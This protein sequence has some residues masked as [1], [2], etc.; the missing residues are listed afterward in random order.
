MSS[1]EQTDTSKTLWRPWYRMIQWSAS[2]VLL[3]LLLAGFVLGRFQPPMGQLAFCAFGVL[4]GAAFA[5]MAHPLD[6]RL[7]RLGWVALG[8]VAA[9]Q[10]FF[11][12]L[13]WS[14][15]WRVQPSVLGWRLWW[16]TVVT[17]VGLGWLQVLWR[18]GARWEW[19]SG[20]TTLGFTA[21][22]GALL[23][24][25][26]FRANPSS[27]LPAWW[28][29]A[30]GV[31]ALGA[32]GGSLVIIGRW[33]KKR[34]KNV[35]PLPPWMRPAL[36]TGGILALSMGSFYIGRVT[37]PPPSPFDIMPSALA[38]MAPEQLDQQI[39]EDHRILRSLAKGMDGLR[40]KSDELHDNIARD[41]K[42]EGRTMYTP[43]ENLKIR[44]I[45][46]EY[47][48][49]RESLIRMAVLYFG[50][51]AVQE[52]GLRHRAYMIGY[53]AAAVALEAG[54]GF[55]DLYLEDETARDKLNEGEPGW[56][57]AGMFNKVYHSV[58]S[59]IHLRLFEE[60][61]RLF[62][63]HQARWR[64]EGLFGKEDF[65][66][67]AKRINRGQLAVDS[68]HLD[69]TSA[70][71]SRIGRRLQSDAYRPMYEA[72]ELVA[73]LVGDTRIVRRAAFISEELVRETLAQHELQP[74]DI[75]LERRNWYLSNAFLP[76]FWPHTALY[77]GT[78][79]QLAELGLD[80][81]ALGKPWAAYTALD[82]GRP[83]V[84][85][86]AVSEGVVFASAE[87]SLTAD[88]VAVL[89]PILSDDEKKEAIIRA[90]KHH[91]KPYD[92]NFDFNTADK[93]VC[94][95]LVYH[96]YE[97]L[98]NFEL[99]TVVGKRVVTPLGIM[100]KFVNERGTENQQLGF[101]LFLDTLPGARK[102]RIADETACCKSATRPKVFNE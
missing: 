72:Q 50:Y 15:T 71:L 90:F 65:V 31:L 91:G 73:P 70:L 38:A 39:E 36:I 80:A 11:Q 88:Y 30:A 63:E 84:I 48:A 54:R 37:M 52:Q 4:T 74:G 34:P 44:R 75:I 21:G 42:R 95:E 66:W 82:H 24:S 87:H 40:D 99:E 12:L 46:I 59:Q 20:R 86:E 101:V 98:L 64:K 45:F 96:A 33:L 97:G 7:T 102:A 2:L 67:L 22:L 100:N 49:H 29:W 62:E 16:V 6:G 93:L 85:L 10:V 94:S 89:R 8:F 77:I 68:I 92:F 55:V 35:R 60:H 18:S 69:S 61:G 9:S 76:G 26:A 17:A 14:E 19:N 23:V 58:T 32:V 53:A 25:L 79:E 3:L 5:R 41:M 27:P 43:T 28:H 56:L 1:D 13:V 83:R 51:A 78:P 57:E 47:L 81:D